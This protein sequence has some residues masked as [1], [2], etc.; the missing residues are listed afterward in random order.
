MTIQQ[1][2]SY[3]LMRSFFYFNVYLLLRDCNLYWRYVPADCLVVRNALLPVL[4][5]GASGHNSMSR[6]S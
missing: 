5:Q 3:K 1:T 2:E 4:L 6:K